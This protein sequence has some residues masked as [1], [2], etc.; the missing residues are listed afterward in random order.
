MGEAAPRLGSQ[1]LLIPLRGI[2]LAWQIKLKGHAN[3]LAADR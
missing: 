2:T 1:Q 3:P